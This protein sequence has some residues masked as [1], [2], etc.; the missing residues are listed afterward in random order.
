MHERLTVDKDSESL[1]IE[2]VET[3]TWVRDGVSNTKI[4]RNFSTLYSSLEGYPV[5][6]GQGYQDTVNLFKG[7]EELLDDMDVSPNDLFTGLDPKTQLTTIGFLNEAAT[8]MQIGYKEGWTRKVVGEERKIPGY[9]NELAMEV[10]EDLR[11]RDEYITRE[12][13]LNVEI[14]GIDVDI[15]R[16]LDLIPVSVRSSFTVGGLML[17]ARQEGCTVIEV[18]ERFNNSTPP[19]TQEVETQELIHETED[20]PD[21]AVGVTRAPTQT[22]FT[23][24][25]ETA[26]PP[27]QEVFVSPVNP[28]EYS[29]NGAGGEFP[30]GVQE[31]ARDAYYIA[32][33]IQKREDQGPYIVS[34]EEY[35][36]DLD[37][38]AEEN[39]YNI[40]QVWNGD[41][42]DF[43]M[44]TT[45]S[46]T[47]EEGNEE[48]RWFV[49]DE[50]AFMARPDSLP[51]GAD[52][53]L[54]TS[55]WVELP[56]N[57]HS[58]WR[59]NDLDENFYMYAV[60]SEDEAESWFNTTRASAFV[61]GGME[62][63]FEEIIQ[64]PNLYYLNAETV[65]PIDATYP[66]TLTVER[67]NQAI[68]EID[69]S[70]LESIDDVEIQDAKDEA[71]RLFEEAGAENPENL[72]FEVVTW[73]ENEQGEVEW[74][75]LVE[76]GEKVGWLNNSFGDEEA[77]YKVHGSGPLGDSNVDLA[78]D[79]LDITWIEKLGSKYELL[80]GKLEE[81]QPVLIER[82]DDGEPF[83]WFDASEGK[84]ELLSG[85]SPVIP[86]PEVDSF[87]NWDDAIELVLKDCLPGAAIQYR[88]TLPDDLKEGYG[89]L[90]LVHL[91]E[92][93]GLEF[94]GP[95]GYR[96]PPGV[97]PGGRP[98]PGTGCE[99]AW[100][101]EMDRSKG[102]MIYEN[103]DGLF[104]TL[105]AG[106]LP[107]TRP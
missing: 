63:G 15:G 47:N 72:A 56:E 14:W 106:P 78:G 32:L 41:L 25:E 52:P 7:G 80:L 42:E 89:V 83:R 66:D 37:E 1:I 62:Q 94:G 74:G 95:P 64:A 10:S 59:Y 85:I 20:L 27:V 23:L 31:V 8:S 100:F 93:L 18:I 13:A 90:Y 53:R 51:P 88:E 84:M 5:R 87:M 92:Q 17:L 4:K 71:I 61:E 28:P 99:V 67:A 81:G 33:E 49:T 73:Q 96:S 102:T 16:T 77:G 107:R 82:K 6:K 55:V 9:L 35:Y 86:H 69:E 97:R 70:N 39:G 21:P 98:I 26:T 19:I 43:Q 24:I 46:R 40:E 58:E 105:P 104:V 2:N 29:G 103:K 50:G 79:N 36:N 57:T 68:E 101:G 65:K 30:G 22:P 48:V 76:D 44:I 11:E 38:F 75:L 12:N 45:L 54:P 34:E 60:N 91:G 3:A